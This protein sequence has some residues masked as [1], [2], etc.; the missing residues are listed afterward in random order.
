MP[1]MRERVIFRKYREGDIVAVFCDSPGTN[2]PATVMTYQTIGQ[3]G[4][5]GA[6]LIMA[7]TV[8]ASPD[9]YRELAG[10][11]SRVGYGGF[12]IRR[13]MPSNA[14]ANRQALIRGRA[15]LDAR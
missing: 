10:E 3:H 2:N 11:L 7:H 9:E 6:A 4:S 12:D 14:Y 1:L 13:R 15:A 8:P 5:A